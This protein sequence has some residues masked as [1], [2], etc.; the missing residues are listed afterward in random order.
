LK[1][2]TALTKLAQRIRLHLI[3]ICCVTY[4]ITGNIIYLK[5]IQC[6]VANKATNNILVYLS[7]CMVYIYI[8]RVSYKKQGYIPFAGSP[9]L[10]GVHGSLPVLA[11]VHVSHL[12]SFLYCVNLRPVACMP[13]VASVS[14][15]SFSVFSNFCLMLL[16]YV[17]SFD[18]KLYD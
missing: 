2:V 3:M 4:H 16:E 8:W 10:A 13:N 1:I 6:W 18:I 15:L 11:G 7:V 14:G 5:R 12:F 9:V 17:G